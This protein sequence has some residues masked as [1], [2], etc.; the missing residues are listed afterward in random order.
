MWKRVQKI[1]EIQVPGNRNCLAFLNVSYAFHA[2][3]SFK[4][5]AHQFKVRE[6]FTRVEAIGGC[7]KLPVLIEV[8]LYK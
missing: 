7:S 8:E 4:F 2:F 5:S 6:V 3:H 1:K